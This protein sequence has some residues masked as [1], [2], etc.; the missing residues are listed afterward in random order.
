MI[1]LLKRE[2]TRNRT[3]FIVYCI[4]SV[5]SAWLYVALFPSIQKQSEHLNE[6]M[7]SFPPAM[8]EAFGIDHSGYSTVEKFLST[9]LMSFIWP[10]LAIL[11]AASRTGASIAGAIDNRT[12]GLEISMPVS[13]IRLYVSKLLGEFCAMALFCAVSIMCIIPL[14]A[15]HGIDVHIS[16]IVLLFAICL[17]FGLTLVSLALFVS[18]TTTEKGHVYFAVGGLL[19]ASYVA[20][21]VAIIS[22]NFSWLK[23]FSIFHYFASFDVLTGKSISISSLVFFLLVIVVSTVFGLWRFRNR[24]IPV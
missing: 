24:D 6:I 15:L 17:L 3:S 20:N 11:F 5:L 10:I 14:C 23:H 2:F 13:R 18:A 12:L 21:I 7:K 9:E 16:R 8:L 22:S 1:S 19:F 4:I